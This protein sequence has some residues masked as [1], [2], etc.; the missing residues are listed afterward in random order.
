ME[1]CEI[2]SSTPSQVSFY[3][4]FC[5]LFLKKEKY[6]CVD[7]LLLLPNKNMLS[8]TEIRS[9]VT[10]L[11]HSGPPSPEDLGLLAHSWKSV[12][13]SACQDWQTFK[14]ASGDLFA[15]PLVFSIWDL[16]FF[17]RGM[18]LATFAMFL[19]NSETLSSS[20]GWHQKA[21]LQEALRVREVTTG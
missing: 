3:F 12:T 6:A 8:F 21:G 11:A 2:F 15:E 19:S 17:G 4:L 5:C 18:L 7:Y 9:A 20:R 10:A 1:F 14:M 13:L 16:M